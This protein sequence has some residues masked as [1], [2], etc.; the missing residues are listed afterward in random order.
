MFESTGVRRRTV[1]AGCGG[2]CVAALGG[3]AAY[4]PVG[5]QNS[6][7]GLDVRFYAAR[8]YSLISPPRIGRRLICWQ[9][10]SGAA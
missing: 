6:A 2:L 3:C 10:R 1:L 8:S 7:G 5:F 4:G 9:P